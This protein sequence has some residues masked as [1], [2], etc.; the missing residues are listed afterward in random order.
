MQERYMKDDFSGAFEEVFGGKATKS[1]IDYS[2]GKDLSDKARAGT[3]STFVES[4]DEK[5]LRAILEGV[6]ACDTDVTGAAVSEEED[7]SALLEKLLSGE[8]VE[9]EVKADVEKTLKTESTDN[10]QALHALYVAAGEGD[11]ETVKKLL[12]DKSV[13]PTAKLDNPGFSK[14]GPI[15]EAGTV[16]VLKLFLADSRVTSD[17]SFS[18]DKLVSEFKDKCDSA[19]D[20]AKEY[21]DKMISVLS[22]FK[23]NDTV[24]TEGTTVADLKS[25]LAAL[26]K[27]EADEDE[28]SQAEE[29]SEASDIEVT[30]SKLSE[31]KAKLMAFVESQQVQPKKQDVLSSIKTLRAFIES[32]ENDEDEVEDDLDDVDEISDIDTT[33][34]DEDTVA[35]VDET[36]IEEIKE[37]F[38][39]FLNEILDTIG[40]ENDPA[41]ES[42]IIESAKKVAVTIEGMCGKKLKGVKPVVEAK[43][44]CDPAKEKCDDSAVEES[45]E[46]SEDSLAKLLEA[47]K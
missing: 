11:V 36:D 1:K 39:D 40:A 28:V 27:E 6:D 5:Y 21:T 45:S 37:K 30:E 23:N 15:G 12:A 16:E 20:E 8:E 17:S 47:L 26:F 38:N 13:D 32:A 41:V 9:E 34:D 24:K 46:S 43:E 35:T 2:Q 18:I 4:K 3:L 44:T 22:S 29:M 33:V 14:L 25:K 31:L 10:K 19:D 42:K 7:E